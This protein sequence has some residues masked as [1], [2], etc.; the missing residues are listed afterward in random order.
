MVRAKITKALRPSRV[1]A[2]YLRRHFSRERALKRPAEHLDMTM[3]RRWLL[4]RE[5]RT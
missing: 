4:H 5:D 2:R 1:V 3:E